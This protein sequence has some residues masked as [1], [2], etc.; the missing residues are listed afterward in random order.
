MKVTEYKIMTKQVSLNKTVISKEVYG[1]YDPRSKQFANPIFPMPDVET[2]EKYNSY[3]KL[4]DKIQNFHLLGGTAH[5]RRST[6][7][8]SVAE[9]LELADKLLSKSK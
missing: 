6:M 1:P 9:A 2:L 4:V 8:K 7:A 3:Y 5:Y